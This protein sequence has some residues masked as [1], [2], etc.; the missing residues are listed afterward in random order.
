MTQTSK[1][2]IAIKFLAAEYG[3]ALDA[4]T[5]TLTVESMSADELDAIVAA[6]AAEPHLAR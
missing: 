1:V 5:L 3:D 6:V 4:E 2:E